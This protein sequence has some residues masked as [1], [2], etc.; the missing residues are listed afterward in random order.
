MEEQVLLTTRHHFFA[1]KKVSIVWFSSNLCRWQCHAATSKGWIKRCLHP[2]IIKIS[3]RCHS[4]NQGLFKKKKKSHCITGKIPCT[5]MLEHVLL[6]SPKMNPW[7]SH[8]CLSIVRSW[9]VSPDFFSFIYRQTLYHCATPQ[10]CMYTLTVI[11]LQIFKYLF[12]PGKD[13]ARKV[14]LVSSTR[15]VTTITHFFPIKPGWDILI[16]NNTNR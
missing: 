12:L 13:S 11:Y 5:I 7:A 1:I 16:N 3:L 15:L 9:C 6:E 14:L 2:F 10:Y 8:P 4:F